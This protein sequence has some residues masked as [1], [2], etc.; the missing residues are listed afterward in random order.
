MPQLI[1]VPSQNGG[2]VTA[3]GEFSTVRDCTVAARLIQ[4]MSPDRERYFSAEPVGNHNLGS[5]RILMSPGEYTADIEIVLSD[6]RIV[7]LGDVDEVL[8]KH[9]GP[10][11]ESLIARGRKN[12][13][14]YRRDSGGDS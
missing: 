11:P 1:S 13:A 4:E 9:L 3:W 10:T 8:R 7:W 14:A 5:T 12:S 2:S 6:G